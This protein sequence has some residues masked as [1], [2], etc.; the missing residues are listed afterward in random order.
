MALGLPTAARAKRRWLESP[1]RAHR[2]GESPADV[3]GTGLRSRWAQGEA[4]K[5]NQRLP[6]GEFEA[7]EAANLA[8]RQQL[9]GRAS[10]GASLSSGSAAKPEQV[11]AD[12]HGMRKAQHGSYSSDKPPTGARDPSE[13]SPEHRALGLS[14]PVTRR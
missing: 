4:E 1:L 8:E 11:G 10:A 9:R 14:E 3:L 2:H 6:G 7:A 12:T 5:D 13:A